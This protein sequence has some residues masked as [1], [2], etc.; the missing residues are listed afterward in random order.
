MKRESDISILTSDHTKKLAAELKFPRNGQHPEQMFKAIQDLAFLEQLVAGGFISGAFVMPVDD[1]L[2]YSGRDQTGIY[3]FFRGGQGLQGVG[4]QSQP[5]RRTTELH[6]PR[7]VRVLLVRRRQQH[8]L[9]L[10]CSRAPW[11]GLTTRCSGPA[12]ALSLV[13]RGFV[14]PVAERGVVRLRHRETAMSGGA[15][16]VIRLVS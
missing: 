5:A 15:I 6:D 7:F 11:R 9:P 10:C 14:W 2:F 4:S 1:P 3:S 13:R 16:A 12:T 8:E